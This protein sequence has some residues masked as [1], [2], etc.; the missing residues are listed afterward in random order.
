MQIFIFLSILISIRRQE[1]DSDNVENQIKSYVKRWWI[2]KILTLPRCL[3]WG[4]NMGNYAWTDILNSFTL[5]Y[6]YFGNDNIF[7][8]SMYFKYLWSARFHH[9]F[10][11]RYSRLCIIQNEYSGRKEDFLSCLLQKIFS[12]VYFLNLY[13]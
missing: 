4:E 5:S 6:L 7:R 2:M 12:S 9:F 13:I 1:S 10:M 3:L 8:T 11:H